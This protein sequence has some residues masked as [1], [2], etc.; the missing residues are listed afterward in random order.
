MEDLMISIPLSES[1]LSDL[2]YYRFYHPDPIVLRR[3]EVVLLRACGHTTREI[4]E[5]TGL[6]VKTIRVYLHL[7][8]EGG[9]DAILERSPRR[10]TSDL[11]NHRQ[12]IEQSF[13]E[14]PPASLKE[15]SERIFQLT[16]IRRSTTRVGVFLKKIG[17]SFL[18]TGSL[19]AK[20][21]PEQQKEFLEKKLNP[22]IE[23]AKKKHS[24]LFGRRGSFC[25]GRILNG[26]VVLCPSLRDDKQR[27]KTTQRSRSL[28]YDHSGFGNGS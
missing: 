27:T 14:H 20:A 3:C 13:R 8:L 25:D 6:N 4:E 18:K 21:D 22:A 1:E 17:M 23:Q 19:P 10:P 12:T 16:G 28:E 15:A 24:S 5:L 9:V 26:S 2:R 7:Y 11:E